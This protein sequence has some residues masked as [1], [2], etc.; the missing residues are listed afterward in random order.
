VLVQ[1]L[2]AQSYTVTG[3]TAS[4]TYTFKVQSRNSFGYSAYSTPVAILS[5]QTPNIPAAPS[6]SFIGD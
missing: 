2:N 5:A 6:T 3:L 4:V 1:F